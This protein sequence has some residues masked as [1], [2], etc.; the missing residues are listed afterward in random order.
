MQE[1]P[2]I[3]PRN[4]Y[5]S[6][7]LSHRQRKPPAQNSPKSETLESLF[8]RSLNPTQEAFT[9]AQFERISMFLR[10]NKHEEWSTVP[11]LYTVL[12]LIDQLDAIGSF[13]EDDIT[14]I[15]FPFTESTLPVNLQP[16]IKLSFIKAQSVVL[17]KGFRLEKDPD[18]KHALFSQDECLPFQVI[19]QLGRGAHGTVDKV[20]NVISQSEYARKKFRRHKGAARN[21]KQTF[22]EELAVLKRVKHRH[23]I[24][25]VS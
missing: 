10:N 11:S 25:L 19:A 6:V 2:T 12:R 4:A 8:S 23:C 24:E 5:V 22:F 18:R 14:D 20:M 13:L 16:S 15:C 3:T 21:H 7:S 17:S 9:D 1:E